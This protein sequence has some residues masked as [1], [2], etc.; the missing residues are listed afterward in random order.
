VIAN[1]TAPSGLVSAD[2]EAAAEGEEE[3]A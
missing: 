1:I 3:E 2:N